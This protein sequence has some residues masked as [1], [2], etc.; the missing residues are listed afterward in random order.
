MEAYQEHK[1]NPNKNR[2]V[3]AFFNIDSPTDFGTNVFNHCKM[4]IV[5]TL[6]LVATMVSIVL[7]NIK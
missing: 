2:L 4:F 5:I 7:R 3:K 6:A 1:Y